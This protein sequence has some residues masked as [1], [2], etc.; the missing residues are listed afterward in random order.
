MSYGSCGSFSFHAWKIINVKKNFPKWFTYPGFVLHAFTQERELTGPDEIKAR[1]NSENVNYSSI[2]NHRN[3]RML[4]VFDR[5]KEI[6][7]YT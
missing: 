1:V 2:C 6:H 5:L 3:S 7:I 4:S